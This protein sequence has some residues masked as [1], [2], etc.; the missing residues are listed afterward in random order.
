MIRSKTAM[1]FLWAFLM[2]ALHVVPGAI[3]PARA[4]GSRK[5]DI[6]F[7]SRGIPLAGATVRVCV[8]PASGQPCTPLA[9]IFSDS[10]LTQALANPTTSD[11]MGNYFF[12]AAPG[13][14]MIE[15]SGPQITTKQIPNVILPSDPSSPTFSSIS[16]SGGISAFSL[17]LTGNLTVNGNTTVVGNLAS[18]TLN[19]ANQSTPPGAAGSGTV[20]LYTKTVDK[21]LYYKDETGSE[22][23]QLGPG[24]GAQTNAANTFTAPQN[25]DADFHTKGPNPSFDLTRFGGYAGNVPPPA[26]TCN[27]TNGSATVTCASTIDFANGQGIVIYGAGPAASLS[28][29]AGVAVTPQGILN[30]TTTYSYQVISEDYN[31]GLTAASTAGSTTTGAATLGVNNVTISSC[32]R[33]GGVS[34]CT[35]AAAHNFQSGVQVNILRGSTNDASFEGAFTISSVPS[36]TTFTFLQT[37]TPDKSGT[38]TSGT[39]QVVAKNLVQWTI[40]PYGPIRSFIYRNGVLAGVAQGMD[41]SFIDWGLTFS[42]SAVP[43]YVPGTPPGS[44]TNQWLATT[45][46]SGGTTTTLTLARTAGKT[47][48]S[49]TALHDNSPN[50]LAVCAAMPVNTGGTIYFPASSPQGLFYPINSTLNL[51][52]CTSPVRLQIGSP[53]RVYESI[54]PKGGSVIEGLPGSNSGQFPSFITDY[55]ALIEGLA[56]PFIYDL[57]G[58]SSNST[59]SNLT[60]QCNQSYQSCIYQDQDNNGD[61]VT[62]ILY[63]NI[64]ATGNGGSQPFVMKGGFGFYFD[65]GGFGVNLTGW[66]FPDAMLDTI[67]LGFGNV[68]QQLAGIVTLDKTYFA[69]SAIVID[70]AGVVPISG[71]P[72]HFQFNET[73][74]ESY[75]T[76]LL[77]SAGGAS[78]YAMKFENASFADTLG[79]G[80]TPGFDFTNNGSAGLRFINTFCSNGS[81]PILEGNNLS[82]VEIVSNPGRGCSIIGTNNYITRNPALNTISETYSNATLQIAGAQGQLSFQMA[83]PAAPAVAVSSGGSVPVGNQSYS[84]SA[85]DVNGNETVPGPATVATVTSGNQTVTVTPGALPAGAVGY[86]VYRSGARAQMPIICTNPL[87][88]GVNYVDTFGFSCGN[89]PQTVTLAG[90]S[91]LGTNGFS[92]TGLKLVGSGFSDFVQPGSLT[93]SRNVT[94]PDASGFVP[95]SSYLNSSYD[96]ATRAN[97]AIGANWTVTTGAI[98]VASNSFQGTSSTNA[99]FWNVNPF[100]PD[101]FAE[102]MVTALN[103]GSDFIGPSARVSAGGNWYSCVESNA[104]LIFQKNVA[105][106][107]TNVSTQ[108]V[109]GAVGDVLRIEVQGSTVKCFQNGAPIITQT[110][111]SLAG[112][113]P[114][115]EFFGTVATLKNWSGGNL[116]PLAHLDVEQD[117]VK[118]QHFTQG[119]TFGS[120]TFTA[121]PRSIQNAFLPGAL[122]STWTALTWTLDKAITVTRVQVQAK[123]AP[124]G[125]TTNAVARLSDG[126]T[127]VNVTISAAA[128]DSAAISQNYAAG[129]SIAISVQTAAAGCTTSPADA[130]VVVQ[131]R[132]Q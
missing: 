65:R 85:L 107:T 70:A 48:T 11:G 18:G 97:S 73:L 109:T 37:G 13:K 75:Y 131:Y 116:H 103:A 24:T 84:I 4:Q 100:A 105:G 61:N 87:A 34:T 21:K 50:V 51:G 98:N 9:Q 20:N 27:T 54:I 112:G 2:L 129:A 42:T 94:L 60:L 44:A 62:T 114:G 113:S 36:G 91:S 115:M 28:T 130:N 74:Y 121:S 17:N 110:D 5:D 67:N 96:N 52:A 57:P 119:V 93:A 88:P 22:I 6:V 63:R 108:S 10:A 8:M 23:G 104:S 56:Y 79:G 80:A 25:I 41:S 118:T 120:E 124:S 15:I 66:G 1:G 127:P 86:F 3:G 32:S 106:T 81:Q 45:I 78:V 92:S 132:M 19:L 55:F 26:T 31:G 117:F 16:S 12:Y 77:R 90:S 128:N 49:A 59:L 95:V 38:L 99:A 47:V 33:T 14:Y 39:A 123:T 7:N 111:S 30:G 46:V 29:P 69:G 71:G 76:P 82:G 40:Q 35:T 125:C 101:Q 72:G 43:S 64:Y 83:T 102:A 122:T 126:T 68:S 89:S 53:L 58:T